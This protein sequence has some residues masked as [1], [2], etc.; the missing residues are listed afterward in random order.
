M[1]IITKLR[2]RD[3]PLN[4]KDLADI[5]E[6]AE[7]TIQ[8]WV[9]KSFIPFIKIG[10][11]IRFDPVIMADFMEMNSD[12]QQVK[13]NVLRTQAKRAFDERLARVKEELEQG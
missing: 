4:V 2:D 10:N 9:R 12:I 11:I 6:V 8:A 13:R 1:S 3:Q 7:S 5:L